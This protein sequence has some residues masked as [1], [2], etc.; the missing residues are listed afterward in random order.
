MQKLIGMVKKKNRNGNL[1]LNS[2]SEL[3]DKLGKLTEKMDQ[4]NNEK[5]PPGFN[6]NDDQKEVYDDSDSESDDDD[7]ELFGGDDDDDNIRKKLFKN[8]DELSELSGL[9]KM[10]DSL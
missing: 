5:G 10:I 1:N 4:F 9:N 8:E 2:N 7:N 3:I 6:E